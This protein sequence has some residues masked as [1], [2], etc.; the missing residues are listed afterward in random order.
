MMCVVAVCRNRS[1][2]FRLSFGLRLGCRRCVRSNMLA[3][4]RRRMTRQ[5]HSSQVSPTRCNARQCQYLGTILTLLEMSFLA[6]F[7]R[8]SCLVARAIGST[9]QVHGSAAPRRK[10]EPSLSP[11]PHEFTCPRCLA[12]GTS[13][14]LQGV[15]DKIQ[16]Q[17]LIGTARHQNGSPR[18]QKMLA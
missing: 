14:H 10:N 13:A 7:L 5:N 18:A 4:A 9:H 12:R 3:A 16:Q 1:S 15:G 6:Y 8:Q 17:T 11:V 2:S